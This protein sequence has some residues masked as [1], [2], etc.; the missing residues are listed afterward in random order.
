MTLDF[1]RRAA[2]VEWM[3]DDDVDLKTFDGCLKDLSR[4]NVVTLAHRPTLNF[5]R[6]IAE[7]GLWPKDRP[8]RILDVGSGHGDSLRAIDRWAA[9][10][11]L[12]VSLT[13]VDRN[14]WAAS[15][16]AAAT[17]PGRPIRWVTADVFDYEEPADL[18]LSALFTHHLD[19][20]QLAQFLAWMNQKAI[21]GWLINDLLRDRVAYFGFSILARLMVWH[22]FVRHDGPI[23]I[24]RAFRPGDWRLALKAAQVEGARIYRCFPFRLCVSKTPA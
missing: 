11:G 21:I 19:D 8:L 22:P 13:G 3:D 23:S 4:V 7:A 16:A 6:D 1:T 24:R 12:A 2:L 9:R 18:I 15:S 14:P 20:G 17:P 10:R 5:L